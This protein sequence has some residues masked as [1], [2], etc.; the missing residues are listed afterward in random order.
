[1]VDLAGPN[2]DN[3]LGIPPDSAYPQGFP[4]ILRNIFT[5]LSTDFVKKSKNASKSSG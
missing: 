3:N 4:G 2:D 1:V 5:E